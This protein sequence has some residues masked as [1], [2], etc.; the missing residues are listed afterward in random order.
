MP[1]PP[2]NA[3]IARHLSL[4]AAA[5]PTG[6]ALKVP[7]GRTRGGE[8]DYLAL[9]FAELDAE[10]AAW[11][12]RLTA[13][14]IKRGDIVIGV[15]GSPVTTHD[16]LYEKLWA[17]GNAGVDVP[18]RVLQGAELREIRVRSIDRNDYFRD[19]AAF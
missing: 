19:R 8:I 18:L 15:S 12:A 14:G 2:A 6:L 13:A 17:A 3:N 5:Q 4:M 1:T 10:V 7:R 9:T 11:S 16:A